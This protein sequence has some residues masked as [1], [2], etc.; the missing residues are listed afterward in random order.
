[1]L[2]FVMKRVSGSL[3]DSMIALDIFKRSM[4]S[5]LLLVKQR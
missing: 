5:A 1:M 2:V 4:G 3:G